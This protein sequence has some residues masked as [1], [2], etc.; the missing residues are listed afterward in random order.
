MQKMAE[1]GGALLLMV[2]IL[3]SSTQLVSSDPP[4]LDVSYPQEPQG[5]YGLVRL[6]CTNDFEEPLPQPA[7]FR[8]NDSLIDPDTTLVTVTE[9]GSHYI[10]F[11]FT[12]SQE[13]LFLCET[14]AAGSSEE[15]GLAGS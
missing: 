5:N 9:S 1:N 13:G 10:V 14:S 11:T 4:H 15:V 3:L 8:V 7:S 6:S 12:Q 2:G